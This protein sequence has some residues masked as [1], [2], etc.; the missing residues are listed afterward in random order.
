[1]GVSTLEV[2]ATGPSSWMSE[3]PSPLLDALTWIVTGFLMLK[4]LSVVS[5]HTNDLRLS[6]VI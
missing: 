6:N 2:K 5:S 3:A 4:N 1:M